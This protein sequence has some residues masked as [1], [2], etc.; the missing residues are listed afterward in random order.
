MQHV[1]RTTTSASSRLS[2][3]SRP[4]DWSRP[5]MRSESCSFIWQPN[6]RIRNFRVMGLPAWHRAA[7][8]ERPDPIRL[9]GGNDR[10]DSYVVTHVEHRG[11]SALAILHEEPNGGTALAVDLDVLERRH[12]H[13]VDARRRQ[14]PAC[15]GDGLHGLV[16]RA[17]PDHLHLDGAAL[18]NDA[19]HRSSTGVRVGLARDLENFHW[20]SP[21]SSSTPAR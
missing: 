9:E 7:W 20:H 14:V 5:A 8:V 6:V 16:E 17:R 15:D 2:V 11:H 19:G 18:T 13:E 1:L 3:A 21:P 12:A 4:S 10:L